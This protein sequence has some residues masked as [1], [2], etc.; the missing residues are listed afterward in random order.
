[1]ISGPAIPRWAIC[2][3]SHFSRIKIDRSFVQGSVA[4]GGESTAIIQAIV[5]LAERLGM[6]TTAEGTE[7]RAEFEAMR[8]LG[9][10]QMQGYYFG[11]PMSAGR[12]RPVDGPGAAAGLP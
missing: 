10:A 1:M 2:R 9:C 11:K 12:C 5:A 7:T 3:R 8:R 4:N 6:E